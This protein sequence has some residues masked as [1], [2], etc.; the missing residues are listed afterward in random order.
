M[1][2]R[3]ILEKIYRYAEERDFKP[4]SILS[5]E[6]HDPY[7][8]YN[9]YRKRLKELIRYNRN[10]LYNDPILRTKICLLIKFFRLGYDY[11]VYFCRKLKKRKFLRE[12]L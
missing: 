3:D 2:Q 9:I 8:L 4:P 7:S 12:I 6:R 11:E 5:K 10:L 1:T